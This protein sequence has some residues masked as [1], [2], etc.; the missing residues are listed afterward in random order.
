MKVY[1][2]KTTK[3]VNSTFV[4]TQF[5][6]YD[7]Q[8]KDICSITAPVIK[9]SVFTDYNYCY[10]PK[11]K[12]YYFVTGCTIESHGIYHYS[13]AVDVLATY[14]SQILSK[15][16][17]VKRSA[18]SYDLNLVDDTWLHDTT[19]TEAVQTASNSGLSTVGCYLIT[20]VNRENAQSANPASTMYAMT[21]G[22]LSTF[23]SQMFDL[24]NYSN[25]TDL[26]A[27]YFNP[28]Q[29]VTSCKWIPV[30]W[31][32]VGG[33][34][35]DLSYGWFSPTGITSAKRISDY[36]KEF[37]W[38]INVPSG[39]DWTWKNTEWTHHLMYVPFCGEIE[40]DPIYSG[41][42]LTVT[43]YIDYNTGGCNTVITDGSN[44]IISAINGQAG[45]DVAISQVA[46]EL[47]IPTSKKEALVMG[48]KTLG[49]AI[50]K[51]KDAFISFF[52][53]I[54]ASQAYA[55]GAISGEEM[56][57]TAKTALD[58][59]ADVAKSLADG[60]TNQLL[61]PTVSVS[62]A[63]GARMTTLNR[64]TLII[65]TRHYNRYV[66]A[67]AYTGGMCC[68]IKTLSTLS[69]YTQVA[70]GMLELNALDEEKSAIRQI[71]ES[72]FYIE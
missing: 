20:I 47:N 2:F 23:L 40:I 13:L 45:A 65:Y 48:V 50:S 39:N 62:G 21:E 72:G 38:T 66:D 11:F 70:N 46:G 5:T 67:T 14:R 59:G 63:D 33:T 54:G 1:F 15:S 16:T 18:S 8:L 57:S 34:V 6:E 24:D 31:D 36:G 61:N 49:G 28:Y 7:C 17:F 68:Q 30:S 51:N 10:I 60:L 43:Q 55:R 53:N 4:P 22:L 64:H 52:N 3:R 42:T 29:Y 27:T 25:I 19:F 56:F 71:L 37:T 58:G 9:L 12:R 44:Q 41:K 35:S 32:A 69:G 26:E